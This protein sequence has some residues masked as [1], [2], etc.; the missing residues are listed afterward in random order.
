MYFI[1]MFKC[2]KMEKACAEQSWEHHHSYLDPWVFVPLGS[3]RLPP[4]EVEQLRGSGASWPGAADQL[5][6]RG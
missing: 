4:W 3:L 5:R 2:I 1:V 6:D